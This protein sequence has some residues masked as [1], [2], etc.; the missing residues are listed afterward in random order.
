MEI[1]RYIESGILEEYIL[2]LLNSED[3]QD[4]VRLSLLHP[5][6][7]AEL[8]AIEV[9]I[10]KLAALT[11]IA[12]SNHSKNRLLASL[13]FADAL[14]ALDLNNLPL[15]NADANHLQWIEALKHLIPENPD[16]DVFAEVLTNSPLLSQVLV[17][18]KCDVPEET[19]GDLI[20]SFFILKGECVCTVG[21]D[22]FHLYGGSFLE[23]PLNVEHTI[24][25]VSPYVVGILQH[26]MLEI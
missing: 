20:E 2:G 14:P 10:E 5:E 24:K 12:T 18:T 8:N 6:V 16:Q 1:K 7:K 9:A 13:G 22:T 26:R 11:A 19:H 4:V 3:Q 15:T 21:E 23:I 25:I 17:V